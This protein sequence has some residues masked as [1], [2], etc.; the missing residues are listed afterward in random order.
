MKFYIIR[1]DVDF[2]YYD[3]VEDMFSHN[4]TIF[5][6]KKYLEITYKSLSRFHFVHILKC[7]SQ[8]LDKDQK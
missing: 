6:D 5:V 8:I 4:A 1:R 7:Q 3:A 2:L